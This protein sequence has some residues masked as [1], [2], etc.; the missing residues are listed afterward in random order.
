MDELIDARLI[1][2]GDR[3]WDDWTAIVRCLEPFPRTTILINGRA[4]GADDIAWRAGKAMGFVAMVSYPAQWEKYG[5]PAGPIR[6]Q[7]MLEAL[8]AGP[9]DAVRYCIGFHDAIDAS[10]GTADMLRRARKAARNPDYNLTVQLRK[11]RR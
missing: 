4:P 11:H 8:L 7:Q 2:F 1:I 10:K 9:S 6:N 3:H 5:R